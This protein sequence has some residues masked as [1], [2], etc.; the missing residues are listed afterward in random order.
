MNQP[1]TGTMTI[2]MLHGQLD[3]IRKEK[4]ED[5][6]NL[7]RRGFALD[8]VLKPNGEAFIKNAFPD[9]DI[10][11]LKAEAQK[12]PPAAA[13]PEEAMIQMLKAQMPNLTTQGH[14]DTFVQA[15]DAL[16]KTLNAY[17]GDNK[18]GGDHAREQLTKV[19]D[20]AIKIPE[21]AQQFAEMSDDE[22]SDKAKAF[23]KPA[24]ELHEYDTQK[25]LLLELTAIETSE[26]LE[27]WYA[28]K[29]EAI[30]SVVSKRARD[31]VFD[32]IRAKRNAL[33]DN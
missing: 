1:K 9:M 4:G 22:K 20:M 24:T 11:E 29:R 21:M 19:L 26:A 33:K 14:Y 27:K 23:T 17:F 30:D 28:T 12:Q 13:S 18:A 6:Y 3:R 8:L 2:D 32:A 31:E 15:F 7:A 5:A 25:Q 16:R 10:E